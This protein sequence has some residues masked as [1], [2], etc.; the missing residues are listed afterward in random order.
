MVPCFSCTVHPKLISA[1]PV[2]RISFSFNS[3]FI[4]GAGV[5]EGVG[6]AVGTGVGFGTTPQSIVVFSRLLEATFLFL[7]VYSTLNVLMAEPL[8]F[9]AL[10]MFVLS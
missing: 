7:S 3:R 10:V 2:N 9:L 1:S 5:G 6:A 4:S 8:R